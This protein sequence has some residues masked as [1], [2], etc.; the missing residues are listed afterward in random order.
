MRGGCEQRGFDPRCPR[1]QP[2]LAAEGDAAHRAFGRGVGEADPAVAEEPGAA[3]M[4]TRFLQR[5]AEPWR[6][7]ASIASGMSTLV[8]EAF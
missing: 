3:Q 4:M 8:Y 5:G 2:R 7:P 1:E 6:L